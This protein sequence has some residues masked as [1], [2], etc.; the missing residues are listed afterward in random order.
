MKQMAGNRSRLRPVVIVV[1]LTAVVAG[2]ARAAGGDLDP[3]FGRDGKVATEFSGGASAWSVAIQPDG[4]IVAVGGAGFGQRGFLV[5]RY[6]RDGTL[7]PTFGDGGRVVTRY[8]DANA[9][10]VVVQPDGR[11]VVAAGLQSAEVT[12]IRLNSDGSLDSSFGSNGFAM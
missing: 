1:V 8:R 12:L 10:A 9:R 4:R 7:D 5:A 6:R 11:I 3:T 2:V